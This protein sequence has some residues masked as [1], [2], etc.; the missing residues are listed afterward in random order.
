MSFSDQP[1]LGS[2]RHVGCFLIGLAVLF[3]TSLFLLSWWFTV[4]DLSTGDY[5]ALGLQDFIVPAVLSVSAGI[6]WLAHRL[7]LRDKN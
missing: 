4:Y 2:W 1:S 3:M 7:L 6:V 5:R